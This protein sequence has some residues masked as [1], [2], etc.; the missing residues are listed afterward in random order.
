MPSIFLDESG[1]FT[2]NNLEK[3]FVIASFTVGEPRRTAKRFKAWCRTKFPRKMQN[4]PEIK[5]SD[6]GISDSLRVKTVQYISKLDV[7]IRYSYIKRENISEE[8]RKKSSIESGLLYTHIV[9]ETLE[10][11]LP[12]ADLLFH[13]F[14][15]QRRLKGIS[16]TKFIETIKIHLLP[17]LSKGAQVKIQMVD[18]KQYPNIQIADWIVGALATYLNNKL[19]GKELFEILRNNIIGEGKEMF[20]DYWFNKFSNQKT[21]PQS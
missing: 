19:Q 6:S 18:S 5:Y 17:N 13:V 2:K 15:D 8:F 9:G 16:K 3:Y 14:C 11:Y 1:Q 12:A 20:R 10:M 7:R 21:Q 4:R